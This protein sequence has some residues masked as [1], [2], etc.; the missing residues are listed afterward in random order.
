MKKRKRGKKRSALSEAKEQITK[1]TPGDREKKRAKIEKMSLKEIESELVSW[2][3]P[4][5]EGKGRLKEEKKKYLIALY[6]QT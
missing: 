4:K 2:G 1:L 5:Q 3:L 6:R